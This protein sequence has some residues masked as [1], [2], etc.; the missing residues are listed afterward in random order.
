MSVLTLRLPPLRERRDD[1]L[2]LAHG[3][4]VRSSAKY[5]MNPPAI[6]PEACTVLEDHDWPGNVRQLEHVLQQAILLSRGEELQPRHLH[7]PTLVNRGCFSA[8]SARPEVGSRT[9]PHVGRPMA[10]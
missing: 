10:C 7:L 8:R 9:V 1:I 3:F 5:S 6:S 2:P 4:V